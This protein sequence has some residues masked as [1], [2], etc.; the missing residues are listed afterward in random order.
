MIMGHMGDTAFFAH[1]KNPYHQV[2]WVIQLFCL[3]KKPILPYLEQSAVLPL[4]PHTIS[5][6]QTCQK[7]KIMIDYETTLWL[8]WV[9]Q[10]DM[11]Y[12]MKTAIY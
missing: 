1:A 12:D 11:G 3:R 6:R 8:I 9:S 2:T 5:N 10:V 4:T 7:E